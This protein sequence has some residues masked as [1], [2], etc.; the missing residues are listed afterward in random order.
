M[1]HASH[2]AQN[3]QSGT[4]SP[5]RTLAKPLVAGRRQSRWR[6][7]L[8]DA[9]GTSNPAPLGTCAPGM[10]HA[11]DHQQLGVALL[12]SREQS[13]RNDHALYDHFDG[14][15]GKASLATQRQEHLEMWLLLG[16]PA[17]IV[18][19]APLEISLQAV[20]SAH[21]GE[22]IAV[23]GT[24]PPRLPEALV[25]ITLERPLASLPADFKQLPVSAPNNREVRDR[26][27]AENHR[28]ANDAV[29]SVTETK[30]VRNKFMCSLTIPVAFPGTNALIRA[31]VTTSN[32][33]VLGIIS[34]PLTR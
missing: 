17:L 4:S 25:R 8:R 23:S 32:D 21:A 6:T 15:R 26:V 30:A 18:P 9:G 11:G 16:D 13:F 34:V 19:A 22:N 1:S 14:S 28:R 29:V 7:A 12:S 33:H 27:A 5:K 2:G 10:D 3:T 24:L 20:S 31:T